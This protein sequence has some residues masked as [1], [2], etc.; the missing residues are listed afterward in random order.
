M[1]IS[2]NGVGSSGISF[3]D[4]RT[5]NF[6][7]IFDYI[8]GGVTHFEVDRAAA[9]NLLNQF[10]IVRP[11]I[12]LEQAFS[13]EAVK[14]LYQ[15]GFEQFLELGAG[16]PSELGIHTFVPA[17]NIVYT[18]I[19]PVAVSYGNGLFAKLDNV[20]YVQCD[21]QEIEFCFERLP[22]DP[23]KKIAI[24]F[25]FLPFFMPMN[26]LKLVTQKLY[27]FVPVGSKIAQLFF[28]TLYGKY[29][30]DY[31]AFQALFRKL[32]VD[33]NFYPIEQIQETM[34]PWS[35]VHNESIIDYLDL[36]GNDFPALYEQGLNLGFWAT[37]FEKS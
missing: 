5:P 26:R 35:I 30:P 14:Q 27:D 29:D 4:L 2:N 11:L 28:S 22:L 16:I 32:G 20:S 9:Q 1:S 31:F 33:L 6:S 3:F 34:L 37:F 13:Q 7:R 10:P 15:E 23:V 17:A 36:N 18:D 19:N 24:G 12:R 25:N 21:V 8:R